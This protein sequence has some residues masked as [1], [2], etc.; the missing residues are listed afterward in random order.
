[1]NPICLTDEYVEDIESFMTEDGWNVQKM[2]DVMPKNIV[3]HTVENITSC[4]EASPQDIP[5][6]MPTTNGKFIVGSAYKLVRHKN[7]SLE[8]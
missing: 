6:W 4:K 3:Q 2:K 7:G 1:M 8:N 5:Q